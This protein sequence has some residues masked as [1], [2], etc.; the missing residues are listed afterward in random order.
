MSEI[1][2]VEIQGLFG[3]VEKSSCG[4]LT[5]IGSCFIGDDLQTPD[6]IKEFLF[7]NVAC[8][9]ESE[10]SKLNGFFAIVLNYNE[11]IYLVSDKVRSRPL[12]YSEN[13]VKIVSDNF[14]YILDRSNKFSL[15][16]LS[17]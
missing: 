1:Y 7:A 15:D 9:N 14:Y 13:P 8:N 5:L 3:S 10:L 16:E 12:F 6:Q 2:E 11:V 4:K 17:C